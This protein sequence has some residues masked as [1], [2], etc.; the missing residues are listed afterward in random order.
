[1]VRITT[2][3]HSDDG[4]DVIYDVDAVSDVSDGSGEMHESSPSSYNLGSGRLAG[5]HEVPQIP[6]AQAIQPAA[7]PTTQQLSEE[8][9][10]DFYR[11]SGGAKG[12]QSGN[13]VNDGL[14]YTK[15]MYNKF[16]G[17]DALI[18]VMGYAFDTS[19]QAFMLT[20]S[21]DDWLWEDHVHIEGHRPDRSEDRSRP[22][23][24]YALGPPVPQI[25]PKRP[26]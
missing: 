23:I 26:Y 9:V 20:T 10:E 2:P 22:D 19:H 1:M 7:T 6:Q 17:K 12:E 4:F 13:F 14:K 15:S 5:P 21:Q 18:A 3:T 24:L 25:Q 8:S 11:A 16:M